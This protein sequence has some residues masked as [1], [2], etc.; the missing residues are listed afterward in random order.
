M[1]DKKIDVNPENFIGQLEYCLNWFT[2]IID[3][4]DDVEL[5][6]GQKAQIA[7]MA[8][9]AATRFLKIQKKLEEWGYIT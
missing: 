3:K 7:G 2:E 5:N 8:L 9:R 6:C 4:F 1:T